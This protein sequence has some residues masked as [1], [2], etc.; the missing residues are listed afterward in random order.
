MMEIELVFLGTGGGRFATITQKRRTGGIRLI[1]KNFNIHLDPGPGALVYSLEAGLN[2]QKITGVLVSH[3]HPDHC[4]DA[5]V[6]I[7]AMTRGMTK[8]RGVLAAAHSVL[9]GNENCEPCLSR[10]HQTM[11]QVVVDAKP[12]VS[13]NIADLKITVAKAK[14]SD[15]STVGF[16]FETR[17]IGDIAYTSDTEYFEGVGK[18][19]KNARLLIL[20]AMRPAGSPWK[21]HMTSEDAIKILE[22]A[23]PEMA[24]LTHFGMKMI[25]KEPTREAE[26]IHQKTGVPTIAATDGMRLSISEKIQT[27]TLKKK[28]RGLDEFLKAPKH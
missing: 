10:Y 2:P 7:E 5:G 27:Q 23:T 20:C 6:F 22:E 1:S 4:N 13:F 21:G 3:C 24:V 12:D 15:P 19:Y 14:H 11:P 17:E 28:M 18:P 9:E 16:R 25:F 26:F 8:K